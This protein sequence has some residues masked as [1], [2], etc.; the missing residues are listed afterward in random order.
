VRGAI[1]L[2]AVTRSLREVRGAVDGEGHA[3]LVLDAA[4]VALSAR[5]TL[6]ETSHLTPEDVIRQLWEDHFV[7]RPRRAAP[8]GSATALPN[9][10]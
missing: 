1:D 10:I 6:D 9:P 3:D 8:G 5:V 4:F 2:V 7:L